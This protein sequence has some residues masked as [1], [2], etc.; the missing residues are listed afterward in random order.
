MHEEK[1]TGSGG[2]TIFEESMVRNFYDLM[3]NNQMLSANEL[4]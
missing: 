1:N 3:K 2:E 4:H